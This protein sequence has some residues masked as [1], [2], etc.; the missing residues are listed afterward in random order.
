MKEHTA[1]IRVFRMVFVPKIYF[2][3]EGVCDTQGL[4]IRRPPRK[5]GTAVG[6]INVKYKICI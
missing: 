4:Y 2:K 3:I 5:R 1:V 6:K